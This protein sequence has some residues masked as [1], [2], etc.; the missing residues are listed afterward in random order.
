[1][2][3]STS[4][5]ACAVVGVQYCNNVVV[6]MAATGLAQRLPASLVSPSSSAFHSRALL[7]Y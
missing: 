6:C 3:R 7:L 1:M 5:V 2:Y 4:T